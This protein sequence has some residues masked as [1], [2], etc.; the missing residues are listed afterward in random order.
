MAQG[1]LITQCIQQDFVR[2]LGA[3]EPLPNLVHVGRLEAERLVG[4]HGALIPFLGAAHAAPDLAVI[5]VV[6]QH[7][8]ARDTAHFELF[9][10]HCVVGTLGAEPV[11]PLG[12][13]RV[14]AGDLN[15]FEQSSLAGALREVGA[16][17]ET[18][19]GVIGVWTDAKV[20]FLLYDLRTRFGAKR[21]ATCSALTASRSIDAH[22]RA[23][24]SLG[25]V[26]GV[27]VFH[28]PT[29]FLRWLDP[30]AALPSLAPRPGRSLLATMRSTACACCKRRGLRA[31]PSK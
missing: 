12:G 26:L 25:A 18:P 28:S 30:E 16:T 2:L 20:S 14:A 1:V 31:Q 11:G 13:T 23:L 3:E 7:D 8:P 4:R 17:P 24:E 22:W 15:D 29:S 10:A 5:H 9:R 19:I 6:D 27:E 21:L